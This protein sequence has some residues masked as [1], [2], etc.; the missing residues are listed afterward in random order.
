MLVKELIE[1][2][3]KF[4]PDQDI[5]F[6]CSVESMGGVSVSQTGELFLDFLDN[7]DPETGNDIEDGPLQ[8]LVLGINGEETYSN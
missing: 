5:R 4:N 6:H 2:L 7:L 8:I 1:K 3:S